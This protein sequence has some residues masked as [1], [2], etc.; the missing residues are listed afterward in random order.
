MSH[1]YFWLVFLRAKLKCVACVISRSDPDMHKLSQLNFHDL[2][3]SL[4]SSPVSIFPSPCSQD[5]SRT[6]AW[7][8]WFCIFVSFS[9]RS[10]SS[11]MYSHYLKKL[12]PARRTTYLTI[13]WIINTLILER[14]KSGEKNVNQNHK[15]HRISAQR[16]KRCIWPCETLMLD[17]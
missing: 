5:S 16:M 15:K 13:A 11:I 6:Q 1:Q 7:A 12:F 17:I 10:P 14:Q 9:F 8:R 4:S 3:F 2:H